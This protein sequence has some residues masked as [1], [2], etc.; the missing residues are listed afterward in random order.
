[1]IFSSLDFFLPIAPSW[2]LIRKIVCIQIQKTWSRSC[3]SFHD[4]KAFALPGL[5]KRATLKAPRMCIYN[6]IP[7]ISWHT[8]VKRKNGRNRY[9]TPHEAFPL[10][11]FWLTVEVAKFSNRQNQS[12]R[13]AF[14]IMYVSARFYPL[15]SWAKGSSSSSGFA[16]LLLARH[17][18]NKFGSALASFCRFAR[19]RL[20]AKVTIISETAKISIK[21]F[22]K[23]YFQKKILDRL[24]FIFDL[25]C[26]GVFRILKALCFS[27]FCSNLPD[28]YLANQVARNTWRERGFTGQVTSECPVT[29]APDALFLP[30]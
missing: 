15:G 11:C 1:M 10:L 16:F 13:Y 20:D 2:R 28:A 25:F 17:S 7:L 22:R 30:T 19:L 9:N 4:R 5:S 26:N 14:V 18:S 21:I 24:C 12:A 29:N 27:V 3:C 6:S 8:N 23:V